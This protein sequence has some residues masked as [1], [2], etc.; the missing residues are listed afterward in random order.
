M[1]TPVNIF[2]QALKNKQAQIG[3]WVS[4]VLAPLF[5]AAIGALIEIDPVTV[6]TALAFKNP[7]SV[8]RNFACAPLETVPLGMRHL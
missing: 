6:R 2:K 8:T 3:F 4:L 7:P 5:V 1:Q